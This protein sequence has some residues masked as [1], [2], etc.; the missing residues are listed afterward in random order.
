MPPFAGASIR[1]AN[2]F[3]ASALGIRPGRL[4]VLSH[5]HFCRF[6]RWF[7]ASGVSPRTMEMTSRSQSLMG[8]P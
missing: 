7:Q 5:V 6:M 4:R 8:R 1:S 3:V 2:A